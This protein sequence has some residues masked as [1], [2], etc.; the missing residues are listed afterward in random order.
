MTLKI[1][2]ISKNEL[3]PFDNNSK[4]HTDEQI[5]KIKK[6][7]LQFGFNDPIAVWK[8]DNEIVE[9]HGRLLAALQI[10]DIDLI[11]VIRLDNL[12]DE[13]RRAY[14]LIHNKLT[15]VTGFD[16]QVLESQLLGIETINMSEYDFKD[17]DEMAEDLD[18]FFDY[19]KAPEPSR[20][21][22]EDEYEPI[23]VKYNVQ[24][25]IFPNGNKQED[26]LK[27]YLNQMGI[28]YEKH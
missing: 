15:S 24:V 16:L 11:P 14:S 19:E 22:D 2:Y 23:E 3:K 27:N 13:Q 17:I 26:I 7:I 6:S 28:E 18:D 1:E 4:I 20:T 25:R 21:K 8:E 12:T 10:D 9:G 5:S